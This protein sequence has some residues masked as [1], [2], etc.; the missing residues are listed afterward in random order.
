M[1]CLF[2]Y[3]LKLIIHSQ[4]RSIYDK[5]CYGIA[6]IIKNKDLNNQFLEVADTNLI[7]DFDSVKI[8]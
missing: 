2:T 6:C 3:V 7:V 4:K 1:P 8:C 5:Q